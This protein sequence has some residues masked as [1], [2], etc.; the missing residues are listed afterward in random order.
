MK[1]LKLLTSLSAVAAVSFPAALIASCSCAKYDPLTGE[2]KKQVIN[3]FI[4][5][6]KVPHNSGHTRKMAAYLKDYLKPY[7]MDNSWKEDNYRNPDTPSSESSGNICFDVPASEG[8]EMWPGVTL[9]GHYDM[10]GAGAIEFDTDK[11]VEAV[12]DGNIMHSKNYQTSL[13][14]DDGIGLG[15]IITILKNQNKFKHG[16]LHILLTS[17][18]E[19]DTSGA[20]AI[21]EDDTDMV[22]YHNVINLDAEVDKKITV[23]C[24]STHSTAFTFKFQEETSQTEKTD[25]DAIPEQPSKTDFCPYTIKV[26]GLLGGHSANAINEGRL[27]AIKILANILSKLNY[28]LNLNIISFEATNKSN[29]I[30]NEASVT[31]YIPQT[32]VKQIQEWIATPMEQSLK[33]S[34][35]I[36]KDLKIEVSEN[37]IEPSAYGATKLMLNGKGSW[38]LYTILKDIPFGP[39]EWISEDTKEVQTSNNIGSVY[40]KYT[41]TTPNLTLKCFS[42]SCVEGHDTIVYNYTNEVAKQI[43]GDG[44][45]ECGEPETSPTW[46][47]REKN[48]L[49]DVFSDGYKQVG[50]TPERRNAHS[51]LEC[52]YFCQRSEHKD[53]KMVAVGPL[54]KDPHSVKET[55]YLDTLDPLISS[56]LY[57]LQN[58]N[59][60]Q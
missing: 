22:K 18:E 15:I 50:I 5:L 1:K 2:F 12:I 28:N 34:N 19:S 29:A 59:K 56:L 39:I 49:F 17:D 41:P 42:R 55:L 46:A 57:T 25:F 35:P 11:G 8:C 20:I 36:E 26:S 44:K 16:P 54:I 53:D 43:F 23:S 27:S 48:V 37:Y 52:A 33:K 31:F 13:G 6:V 47:Y 14:A 30:C 32:T 7:Y 9:Q 40:Y 21:P 38:K 45:V 4:E 10:V 24:A 51:W 3:E 60:I 58:I